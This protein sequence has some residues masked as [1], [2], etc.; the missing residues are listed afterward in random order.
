MCQTPPAPGA[1][2]P[3]HLMTPRPRR[4]LH[5]LARHVVSG[6]RAAAGGGL[7]PSVAS[8]RYSQETAAGDA[9]TA[10]DATVGRLAQDPATGAV[11]PAE[12][13]RLLDAECA[14][15]ARSDY[16]LAAELKRVRDVLAPRAPASPYDCA[17]TSVAEQVEFF[18]RNGFCIVPEVVVGGEL[19][20]LQHAWQ[21]AQQPQRERWE[22]AKREVL[23]S[24]VNHPSLLPNGTYA[25][26]SGRFYPESTFDIPNL[27]E[28]DDAFL[29]LVDHPK[30]VG[31]LSAVV[32]S[33][34]VTTPHYRADGSPYNG[35]MRVGGMSGRVVPPEGNEVG[36]I[37]W[38]RDKPPADSWPLP[39]YRIIKCFLNVYDVQPNGGETAVVPGSF[40]L[41]SGPSQT[42]G[43]DFIQTQSDRAKGGNI[44]QLPH[45]LM[46][47][48][49]GFAVPAGW[50]GLFDSS[51]W[52]TSMPNTGDAERCSCMF[53]YRS[54]ECYA[55]QS[56]S[57]TWGGDRGGLT[58]DRL[59]AMAERGAL[60][61]SRRRVLGL[62]DRDEEP[63]EGEEWVDGLGRVRRAE[64]NSA[65]SQGK[66]RN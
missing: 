51:S 50:V 13:K 16:V 24:G 23:A 60:P 62:P 20:R 47:N 46:P 61:V 2:N 41:Q 38:H 11:L 3:A 66:A 40:R 5:A 48:C 58:E 6:S 9:A 64:T 54:S 42:L 63:V 55:P 52:H 59:R 19:R 7:P 65:A 10:M 57:P 17:P 30:L 12:L 32:G 28:Q 53:A 15:A 37:G 49:V 26:E 31:L 18:L 44:G 25:Y 34:G 33:A 1:A 56:R 4:R 35:V 21:R 27:L 45:Q 8:E 36:Y 43:G 39:N 22:A 29:E 14:A